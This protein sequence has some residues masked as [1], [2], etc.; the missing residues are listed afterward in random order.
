M[1]SRYQ[2]PPPPPPAFIVWFVLLRF[3]S[4]IVVSVFQVGN[5]ARLRVA[6]PPNN[7]FPVGQRVTIKAVRDMNTTVFSDSF[8]IED[9]S[10][11]IFSQGATL[12]LTSLNAQYKITVKVFKVVDLQPQDEVLPQRIPHNRIRLAPNEQAAP[13]RLLSVRGVLG[14]LTI[15]RS[16]MAGESLKLQEKV[17]VGADWSYNFQGQT[18]LVPKGQKIQVETGRT[19]SVIYSF[20]L[21][22][23]KPQL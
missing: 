12:P 10:E 22:T 9:P 18:V 20:L 5:E 11:T 3:A 7:F 1:S 13:Q 15:L 2:T 16:L 4:L 17:F 8:I 21:D 14:S 6:V 23:L 19:R